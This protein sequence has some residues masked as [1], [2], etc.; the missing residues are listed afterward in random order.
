MVPSASRR[1]ALL[2]FAALALPVGAGALPQ[3][4][5]AIPYPAPLPL[6]SC[7]PDYQRLCWD[8]T[9]DGAEHKTDATGAIGV[10]AGG[11]VAVA[12]YTWAADAPGAPDF[13]IL[14]RVLDPLTGAPLWER[15]WDSGGSA[16]EWADSLA[17][18]PDGTRIFVG[19][20]SRSDYVVLAFEAAT[21]DLAWVSRY[22]GPAGGF[23][24]LNALAVS[25]DGAF[26]A[27]TGESGTGLATDDLMD[28]ATVAFDAGS[29]ALRWGARFNGPAQR[30]DRGFA[31]A[32]HPDSGLVAV[33]GDADWAYLAS[34]S[35]MPVLAYRADGSLAWA[36]IHDDAAEEAGLAVDFSPS[37]GRVVVAG[38]VGGSIA[39]LALDE[40]SGEEAWERLDLPETAL[41]AW[42][43]SL[44]ISP[45]G[46]QVVVAGQA[47][48][49][50]P[51]LRDAVAIAYDVASGAETWTFTY[52]GPSQGSEGFS[53][54]KFP[55]D[56]EGVHIVGYSEGNP[57]ADPLSG[58]DYDVVIFEL[59]PGNGTV[60]WAE[61]Y[62][63]IAQGPDYGLALAHSADGGMVYVAGATLTEEAQLN[64]AFCFMFGQHCPFPDALTLA[65][66]RWNATSRGALV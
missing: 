49:G 25:A 13:D 60:A 16:Y 48:F 45:D 35:S 29:G 63:R 53:T 46:A 54:V 43:S 17:V 6:L 9:F 65:Y 42:A 7:N 26:V 22:D 18:S 40:A 47:N 20:T 12:G 64:N 14:V 37:Q 55:P 52:N 21:G 58:T 15:T 32:I 59:F 66:E 3:D 61:R 8:S 56:G 11:G 30:N 41:S 4:R 23:D 19:G 2:V 51:R 50:I 10:V 33:T 57:A 62:G 31:L 39:T 1:A 44:A 28:V 5:S 24:R 34:G 38:G 36:S 27:A